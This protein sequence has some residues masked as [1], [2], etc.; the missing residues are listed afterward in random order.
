MAGFWLVM[1][2]L[3]ERRL[4]IRKRLLRSVGVGLVVLMP[5]AL[6]PFVSYRTH[7]IGFA[8]GV[9]GALTYFLA[10][11]EAIRSA[12][13]VEREELDQIPVKRNQPDVF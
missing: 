6:Q 3:I 9:A 10:R 12:E 13:V 11:K 5:A 8:V 4:P 1:Y 7:A 2:V